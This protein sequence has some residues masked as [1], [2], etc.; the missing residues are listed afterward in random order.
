[1][2][3]EA[4]ASTDQSSPGQRAS[5]MWLDECLEMAVRISHPRDIG[6]DVEWRVE[7]QTL[8]VGHEDAQLPR[9]QLCA[10]IVRMTAE[11]GTA[12]MATIEQRSQIS[13]EAIV[14][15]HQFVQLATAGDVLIF[16]QLCLAG[17]WR[18]H[19]RG[20]YFIINRREFGSIARK[21]SRNHG[22]AMSQGRCS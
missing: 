11:R 12:S 1:M 7:R 3:F 5:E 8:F 15:H 21:E 16:E 9:D 4:G 6:C 10:E 17:L 2:A 18:S 22:K 14:A 13:D 19:H 20:Y